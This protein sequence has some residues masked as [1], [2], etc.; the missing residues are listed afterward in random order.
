[1]QG[2]RSSDE[3]LLLKSQPSSGH[4]DKSNRR[5]GASIVL[6]LLLVIFPREICGSDEKPLSVRNLSPV[7]QLYGLPRATGANVLSSGYELTFNTEIANNFSSARQ[8]GAY[9]FFDGETLVMSYGYRRS[10]SEKIEFSVE[11]PYVIHHGG[12]ADAFIDGFHDAFKLRDGGRTMAPR[13]QIDYFVRFDGTTYADFQNNRSQL[14]DIRLQGGYQISRSSDRSVAL[15]TQLKL[16]TGD[17]ANL[18]GSE[19][20]DAALWLS[21]SEHQLLQALAVGLSFNGGVVYLGKGDLAPDAQNNFVGFGH[22]GFN[23]SYSDRLSLLA[24]LDGHTKLIDAELDQLGGAALEGS[25]G[26]RFHFSSSFWGEIG[27]VEDLK[28]NSSSDVV[29]QVIIGAR[30]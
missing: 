9:A 30:L 18:S 1:M 5:F 2:I 28:S 6:F 3:R 27:V 15:R 26:A 22:L 17:L 8:N 20:L 4:M 7:A 25:I 10:L 16:P 11:V 21:Y 19:A 24:Q 14:G 12:I 13:D 29:F 23:Y